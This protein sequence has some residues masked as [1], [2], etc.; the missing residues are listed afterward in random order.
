MLA[1]TVT[2]L[3]CLAQKDAIFLRETRRGYTVEMGGGGG[4]GGPLR[5]RLPGY[6]GTMLISSVCATGK[7]Q[8]ILGW[9][10]VAIHR[11]LFPQALAQLDMCQHQ[12]TPF[13]KNQHQSKTGPSPCSFHNHWPQ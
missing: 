5:M 2:H 8:P 10:L 1:H 4:R 9:S 7:A 6:P 13:R 11:S 3:Y 12:I